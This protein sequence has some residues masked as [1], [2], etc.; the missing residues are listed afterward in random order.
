MHSL[1]AL[2]DDDE[3]VVDDFADIMKS[4]KVYKKQL[5][6]SRNELYSLDGMA[7]EDFLRLFRTRFVNWKFFFHRMKLLEQAEA[8]ASIAVEDD[9]DDDVDDIP[10]SI[11]HMDLGSSSS[12]DASESSADTSPGKVH[13]HHHHHTDQH[14]LE[15][16]P[17]S[18]RSQPDNRLVNLTPL[19]QG[20]VLS[21]NSLQPYQYKFFQIEV[22]EK[23]SNLTIEMT[24]KQGFACMYVSTTNTLPSS[25]IYDYKAA[26]SDDNQRVVRL[27]FVTQR[28]GSFLLA[29]HCTGEKKCKFNVWC[30]CSDDPAK[31]PAA[32]QAV[33][34]VLRKFKYLHSVDS[35]ELE[36]HFPRLYQEAQKFS[37]RKLKEN[38]ASELSAP[39]LVQELKSKQ[40][41]DEEFL[42]RILAPYED[43]EENDELISNEHLDAFVSKVGRLAMK[44]EQ[45]MLD[46][47]RREHGNGR[48]ERLF[49]KTDTNMHEDLFIR[50]A[51]P[52][53]RHTM[54]TLAPLAYEKGMTEEREESLYS[55]LVLEDMSRYHD[56]DPIRYSSIASSGELAPPK[57]SPTQH[58]LSSWASSAVVGSAAF[59]EPGDARKSSNSKPRQMR[60]PEPGKPSHFDSLME[61]FNPALAAT[62][63]GTR[64]LNER[65]M[66]QMKMAMMS[67]SLGTGLGANKKQQQSVSNSMLLKPIPKIVNYKMR[68]GKI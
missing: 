55:A 5:K 15:S 54:A 23:F 66:K 37:E 29:V 9:D 56:K 57:L 52:T 12:S 31:E 16:L 64:P 22:S 19:P 20:K 21:R 1:A 34:K 11:L 53:K 28:K 45:H 67:A 17:E 60:L 26:A 8:D 25:T 35:E 18:F 41:F 50:P 47:Q 13:N 36:V 6:A 40:E 39:S 49:D 68:P 43:T 44:K 7:P 10:L 24:C 30:Y 63:G 32:I 27:S 59:M 51:M 46:M 33:S 48:Q 14:F 58:M 65:E 3:R 42:A 62:A 2:D 4:V 61:G 38:E